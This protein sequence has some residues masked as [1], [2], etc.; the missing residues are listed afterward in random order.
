M[1]PIPSSGRRHGQQF[2]LL[3]IHSSV[4]VGELC[5]G[6]LIVGAA[7]F[8][9]LCGESCVERLCMGELCVYG[10]CI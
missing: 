4:H 2:I 5:G 1:D 6:E 3:S 10:S 7:V 9:E 8:G